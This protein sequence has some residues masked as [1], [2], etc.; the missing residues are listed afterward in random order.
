MMQLWIGWATAVPHTDDVVRSVVDTLLV[1]GSIGE[2]SP[3]IPPLAWDWLNKRPILPPKSLGLHRG[4]SGTVVRAVQGLRDVNLIVSYLL[5]VWSKWGCLLP[6]GTLAMYYL[7]REELGGIGLVGCR[8]DLVQRLD[9]VL[10]ES[11]FD[12]AREYD[13]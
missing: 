8:A 3:L 11:E 10:S 7:I 1:M 4:T 12:W 13:C 6:D 5:I 2:L 9:C